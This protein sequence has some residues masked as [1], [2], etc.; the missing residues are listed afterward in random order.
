MGEEFSVYSYKGK[1]GGYYGL[2]GLLFVKKPSAVKYETPSKVK[3]ALLAEQSQ[4]DSVG[5]TYPDGWVAPELK[6]NWS[7]NH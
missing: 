6:S 1:D 5:K 3:L 7:P 4:Q 2:G